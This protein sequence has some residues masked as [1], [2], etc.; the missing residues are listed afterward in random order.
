YPHDDAIKLA[1]SLKLDVNPTNGVTEITL[2]DKVD[3]DELEA[4][5]A[6]A[7]TETELRGQAPG[8]R[9]AVDELQPD[10]EASRAHDTDVSTESAGH[11]GDEGAQIPA[12]FVRAPAD[13]I[14]ADRPLTETLGLVTDAQLIS[15]LGIWR[16]VVAVD[17]KSTRLN[18]S[19]VSISYAVFCL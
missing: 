10:N 19:H 12:T 16:N 13:P 9:A 7:S 14:F 3:S 18:S 11:Q 6:A 8:D 15:E 1:A 4:R 2:V 17:R 5:L